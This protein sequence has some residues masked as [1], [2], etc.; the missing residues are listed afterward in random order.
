MHLLCD[1]HTQNDSTNLRCE[2][3]T[4]KIMTLGEE[5]GVPRHRDWKLKGG[6]R[7]K[8]AM[9]IRSTVVQ[10]QLAVKSG[11]TRSHLPRKQLLS[12]LGHPMTKMTVLD[13]ALELMKIADGCSFLL[14]FCILSSCHAA[15]SIK[16]ISCEHF[17]CP[18]CKMTVSTNELGPNDILVLPNAWFIV[19]HVQI[20]YK[21][22]CL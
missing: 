11:N 9:Q 10:W 15:F 2:T 7:S 21:P 6:A 17:I 3:S 22:E 16:S 12:V 8:N 1:M 4:D 20:P 13:S 5:D 14:Y 19:C 18:C